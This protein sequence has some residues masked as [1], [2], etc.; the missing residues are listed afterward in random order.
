M[1]ESALRGWDRPGIAAHKSRCRT[2]PGRSHPRK[3]DSDMGPPHLRLFPTP[4]CR[5]DRTGVVPRPT[6][7][8]VVVNSGREVLGASPHMPVLH[9]ACGIHHDAL[10]VV[11]LKTTPIRSARRF[12][13]GQLLGWGEGGGLRSGLV[14][15]QPEGRGALLEAPPSRHP[16][17]GG[18]AFRL[19]GVGSADPPRGTGSYGQ[20]YRPEGKQRQCAGAHCSGDLAKQTRQAT[21]A[22]G[23]TSTACCRRCCWC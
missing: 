20:I 2:P 3:A 16:A 22:T 18:H 6:K 9:F 21:A 5:A 13:V 4:N 12:W 17:A 19:G 11:G 10:F 14:R 1:S 15:H 8:C 7:M 23:T